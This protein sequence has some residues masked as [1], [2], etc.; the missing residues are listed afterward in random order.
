M[1]DFIA[2]SRL[3]WCKKKHYEILGDGTN[4]PL[5]AV[6]KEIEK[7]FPSKP[8]SSNTR[9]NVVYCYSLLKDEFPYPN[10]KS[11]VLY[12]GRTM[13]QKKGQEISLSFRFVHCKD[14]KDCKS[15]MCLRYY[16]KNKV[17]LLLEIYELPTNTTAQVAEGCLRKAFVNLHSA[18]PIADGASYKK[19]KD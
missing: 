10:G 11:N 2:K 14:G 15:N 6:I 8:V 1:N 18:L 19:Q 9:F 7:D 4:G 3:S 12:I 16:Y 17:P 5:N 13:G